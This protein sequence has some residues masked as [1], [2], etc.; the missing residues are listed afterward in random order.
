MNM[1]QSRLKSCLEK[2]ELEELEEGQRVEMTFRVVP[3]GR[4][5]LT[6]SVIEKI[7]T[8]GLIKH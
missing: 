6:I 5:V 8:S 7:E 3:K 2:N 4:E 1:T